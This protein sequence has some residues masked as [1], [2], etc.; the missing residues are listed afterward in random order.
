MAERGRT[1]GLRPRRHL[2][3]FLKAP[4]L[5]AVKRRLARGIGPV[6]AWRFYRQTCRALLRRLAHDRRWR[7]VLAL[8]PDGAIPPPDWPRGLHRVGQGRGDLGARMLRAMRAMPAGPVLL[9]GSDIPGIRTAH[10]SAAFGALGRADAVFG[11]A[12][13]GGY[14]LVGLRHPRRL[15]GLFD[16]V[17]WS[18]GHALDDTVANLPAHR[19]HLQ[20]AELADVDTAADYRRHRLAAQRGHGR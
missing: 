4:R 2:I 17:R 8:T 3:V 14:W 13:D 7:L 10:L 19:R 6:A 9:I 15:P 5:G 16:G 11:P 1:P 20:V 18:T 12:A